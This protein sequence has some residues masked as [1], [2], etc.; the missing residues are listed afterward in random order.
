[1]F[2]PLLNLIAVAATAILLAACTISSPMQLLGPD[3]GATPL[4]SS[5]VV[6]GY[7]KGADEAWRRT[8]EAPISFTLSG[9]SYVASDNSMTL[10]FVALDNNGYLLSVAGNEPGALYG[11]AWVKG[12]IVVIRMMLAD[13]GDA[14]IEKAKAASPPEIAADIASADGGIAI[15]QRATLDH[16]ISLL[17]QGTL[18]TEPLV[19]WVAEDAD[20]PT[21]ATIRKAPNGWEAE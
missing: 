16:M 15:T 11:T 1:M 8:E 12:Q 3:E 17:R 13:D 4:P 5:I 9:K 7:K 2:R 6:Y 18:A 14:V 19:A 20:A 21:P 10:R